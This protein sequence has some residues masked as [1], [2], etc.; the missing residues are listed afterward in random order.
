VVYMKSKQD[1]AAKDRVPA[2]VIV[3]ILVHRQSE[4]DNFHATIIVK[5][6]GSFGYNLDAIPRKLFGTTPVN[7][8]VLFAPGSIPSEEVLCLKRRKP[9]LEK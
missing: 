8:P 6:K 3:P 7:D 2:E 1:E 9:G 4:D 5:G